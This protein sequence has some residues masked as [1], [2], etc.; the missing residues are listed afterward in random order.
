SGLSYTYEL[1]AELVASEDGIHHLLH[2]PERVAGSVI[3]QLAGAMPGVRVDP[4]ETRSTGAATIGARII[5]PMRA[6]LR[7]DEPVHASRVLLSGL[8][9]LRGDERVSLRWALRPAGSPAVPAAVERP[10]TS[11]H[12]KQ[13][14]QGW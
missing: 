3:D 12:A 2:L 1:V 6:L 7:S 10:A 13:G 9:T 14:A 5:V 4:V 11:L 8:T